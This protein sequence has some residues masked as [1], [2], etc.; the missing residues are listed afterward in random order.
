MTDTEKMVNWLRC[1]PG[2]DRL[3]DFRVDLTDRVGEN[4]GLF[5]GGLRELER[6]TDIC[7]DV[8]IR[9]RYV[10]GL[11][12]VLEDNGDNADWLLELQKWIQEQSAMENAPVFGSRTLRVT[13]GNGRLRDREEDGVGVYA[14]E[15]TVDWERRMM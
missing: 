1:F 7:G 5:P 6:K 10:F 4:G 9:N 14:A 15:I 8:V 3:K 13:A 12:F 2:F 11:Y